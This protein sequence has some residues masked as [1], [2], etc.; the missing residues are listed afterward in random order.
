MGSPRVG[1]NPT[2]SVFFFLDESHKF[3]FNSKK[4]NN[5]K[6]KE[7]KEVLYILII[8]AKGGRGISKLI[9]YFST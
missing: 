8:V 4:K 6:K 5:N 1:S 3:A 2:R 9:S 7:N